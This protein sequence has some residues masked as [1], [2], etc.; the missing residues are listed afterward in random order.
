MN[1]GAS[2]SEVDGLDGLD[3]NLLPAEPTGEDRVPAGFLVSLARTI[4]L[5]RQRE[6]LKTVGQARAAWVA[7]RLLCPAA[8]IDQLRFSS[9][10]LQH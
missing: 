10:R 9:S 6:Q 2:S 8:S 7:I 1:N 3:A 4:A 5:L